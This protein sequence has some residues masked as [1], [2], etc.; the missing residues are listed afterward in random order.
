MLD[1][2]VA[3]F[4]DVPPCD[5][6]GDAQVD[7]KLA[8]VFR[9]LLTLPDAARRES[10]L[11]DETADASLMPRPGEPVNLYRKVLIS[12]WLAIYEEDRRAA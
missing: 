6:T 4:G 1:A 12:W 11:E 2:C 7:K 3:W 8:D 5:S 10:F 9:R